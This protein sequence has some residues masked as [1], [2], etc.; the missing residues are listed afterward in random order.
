MQK[1]ICIFLFVLTFCLLGLLIEVSP[2]WVRYTNA[3]SQDNAAALEFTTALEKQQQAS[4]NLT[5]SELA[6]RNFQ[7]L[8]AKV[9]VDGTV[10]VIVRLRVAFRPEGEVLREAELQAQRLT[11]HQ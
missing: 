3:I 2:F 1:Q 4:E 11:I 6:A 10:P 9:Q 5:R 8:E 7:E